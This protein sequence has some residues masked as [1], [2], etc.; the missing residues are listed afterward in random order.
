MKYMLFGPQ[1][2]RDRNRKALSFYLQRNIPVPVV[3]LCILFLC[4]L[5]GIGFFL[6]ILN[7][8]S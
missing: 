6:R 1:N 8:Q 4:A 3:G 2:T 7:T 5:A